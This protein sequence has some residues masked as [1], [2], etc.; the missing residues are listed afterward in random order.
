MTK[1]LLAVVLLSSAF[2]AAGE[3][4]T[5]G[6]LTEFPEDAT[7]AVRQ[8]FRA[9]TERALE[10]AGVELQWRD[11]GEAATRESFDRLVVLRFRGDCKEPEAVARRRSLPLGLTHVS[12]GHVLPFV[13]IDCQR[14]IEAMDGGRW[15]TRMRQ[16]AALLGR[17]LGRVAAHEIHHV[18]SA[19][20]GHDD[21]GLMKRSFDWRDLCGPE[22]NFSP[23]SVRVL[24]RSLGTVS[25][26]TLARAKAST[27]E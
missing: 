24:R 22:L 3:R 2:A 8:A 4:P 7:A 13:E 12:D 26:Q 17:A 14:V 21:E 25:A 18:L 20:G 19:S 1:Q 5:V 23:D 10:L 16:P 15:Q 11:M 6:L 27:D 9:E